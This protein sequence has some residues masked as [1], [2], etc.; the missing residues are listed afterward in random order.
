M[1]VANLLAFREEKSI[2]SF[3]AIMY[4]ACLALSSIE[5]FRYCIL[6]GDVIE[7]AYANAAYTSAVDNKDFKNCCV[8][9]QLSL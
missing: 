3:T 7:I 5:T 4:A 9:S 2:S 1:D 6:A 8:D